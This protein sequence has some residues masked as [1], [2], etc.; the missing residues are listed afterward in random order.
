[1]SKSVQS[2]AACGFAVLLLGA[3][4][5]AGQAVDT[6]RPVALRG[7]GSAPHSPAGVAPPAGYVIGPE[8]VLTILFWRDKDMSGDVAVRPDGMISIPL[9]HDVP[10]AGLTPEQLRERLTVEAAKLVEDPNVTVV[11]KAIHSRKVFVTG[12]VTRP[13]SYPI[14]APTTVMQLLA[15]AGGVLEFADSKN[16]IIMRA[17]GGR[18]VAYPFNYKE[19][20]KRRNLKQNIELKPGDTV[21]VP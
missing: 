6:V 3:S 15:M 13:G 10:A 12:Q 19:V 4:T 20:L 2:I 14:T 8:D 21:V 17:E 1:M 18:Q 7:G 5:V 11:V 9:L 16:I